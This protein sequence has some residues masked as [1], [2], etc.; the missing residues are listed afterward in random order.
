[1]PT[2][3]HALIATDL[4]PNSLAMLQKAAAIA[5]AVSDKISLLHVIERD[6]ASEHIFVNQQE[7]EKIAIDD[8]KK[9]FTK[10]GNA[11]GIPEENQTIIIATPNQEILE[12]AEKKGCDLI[13]VGSHDRHGL[14]K[15]LGSTSNTIVHSAKIDVFVVR[16]IE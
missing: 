8:V 4:T 7:Y 15:L 2:Y 9:Q 11:A 16:Y 14:Q 12:S 6:I 10:L 5:Q 3:K 1:M 13:I